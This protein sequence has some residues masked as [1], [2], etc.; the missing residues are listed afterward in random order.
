MKMSNV[1]VLEHPLIKHKL[2]V[3]RD[4]NTKTKEFRESVN[5][6]AGLLTFEITRNLT[7][8]EKIVETPVDTYKGSELA[9]E[10]VIVPILRAGLGMVEGIHNLIP[11]AKIG[12]IGLYRDEE[13]LEAKEYYS[14]F[15]DTLKDSTIL[16]VDPML[17]TGNSTVKAIEILK[18]KGA[19]HIIFVGI[20]GSPEGVKR[21]REYDPNVMIYLAAL[22]EKLNKNG[23]IVP[24]LGDA[25]DRLFGTK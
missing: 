10:I 5:E 20:V 13:T 11:T 6:I 15:P 9:E 23:Y 2:T 21:L 19:K 18:S 1:H 25:G 24:G 16:L 22:D 4:K 17:A 14:K 8:K 7:L 12:H 3:I